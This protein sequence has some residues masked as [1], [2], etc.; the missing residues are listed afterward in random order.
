LT[1]ETA[2]ILAGIIIRL[3]RAQGSSEFLKGKQDVF[4][5]LIHPAG[6]K[7]AVC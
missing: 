6:Q 7:E 4:H 1:E 3:K 5:L 2:R